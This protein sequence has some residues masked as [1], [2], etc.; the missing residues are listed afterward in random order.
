MLPFLRY[1]QEVSK[2]ENTNLMNDA[3]NEIKT[4][5][6]TDYLARRLMKKKKGKVKY[7]IHGIFSQGD[8]FIFTRRRNRSGTR[9]K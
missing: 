5:P 9:I 1:E 7:G 6:N 2:A 8:I 4:K 3:K